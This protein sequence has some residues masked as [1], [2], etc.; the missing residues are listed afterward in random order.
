MKLNQTRP[1]PRVHPISGDLF[2]T[3]KGLIEKLG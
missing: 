1:A 3:V 2:A